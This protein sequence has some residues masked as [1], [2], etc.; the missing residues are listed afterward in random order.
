LPIIGP[1][2]LPPLYAGWLEAL[3]SGPLPAQ[4]LATCDSCVQ[5]PGGSGG[6][7][8]GH[9]GSFLP[10][11]KCC[12]YTPF[13]PNFLVGRILRDDDP[14]AGGGR[15]SVE[16]R[17]DVKIAV[18]PLGLLRSIPHDQLYTH[19]MEHRRFGK[20]P[21]MRCPHYQPGPTA[22]CGIWKNRNSICSTWFCRHT[23]GAV[24]LAFYQHISSLLGALEYA[25]AFHCALE[26]G[27]SDE[28]LARLTPIRD[29][30]G[31]DKR[32]GHEFSFDPAIHSA[33]WGTWAGREREFFVQ[34]AALVDHLSTDDVLA[35]G[36]IDLR[37][38]ARHVQAAYEK[39]KEPVARPLRPGVFTVGR[40][41]AEVAR[42]RGQ[43]DPR[44]WLDVPTN[45][46][47][48]IARFDGVKATDTVIEA[49]NRDGIPIDEAS[50][51]QLVDFGFLQ[52]A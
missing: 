29:G 20:E 8:L 9:P 21:E 43:D 26:L 39:M 32:R 11:I 22:N 45:L 6:F 10:D 52:E 3:V 19:L 36:G 25:I 30:T 17:I 24:E 33:N 18:T 1:S 15:A 2:P 51:Q 14:A 35:I 16:K 50:V 48:A 7:P 46:I 4:P 42:L 23:R 47:L 44:T 31:A 40:L 27:V 28:G 5:A 49:C 12:G 13:L 41:S 38:R 37:A 34:S